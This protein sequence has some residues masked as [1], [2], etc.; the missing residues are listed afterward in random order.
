MPYY[1]MIEFGRKNIGHHGKVFSENTTGLWSYYRFFH[2]FKILRRIKPQNVLE[3]G[4]GASTVFIAEVLRLNEKDYNIKGK[5]IS[6]EQSEKYYN[7]LIKNFPDE[8]IDFAEIKLRPV[9]LKWYGAYRGI[10]Y[11]FDY[12][13]IPKN[14]DF[15]Y[16]DGATR[17]RGNK[18]SN[19]V[20]RRLNSDIINLVNAGIDVDYA[21]TDHRYANFPFYQSELGNYFNIKLLKNWRSIEIVKK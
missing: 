21:I 4:G 20:Y 2:L 7:L 8:L 3:F 11:D 1:A 16:I 5:C 12:K 13:E 9:R 19:F 18:K 17:T 15:I 6:F 14:I 10:Y